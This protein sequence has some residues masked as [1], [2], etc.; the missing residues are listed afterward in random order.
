[1]VMGIF[2]VIHNPEGIVLG[3]I[4]VLILNP[5]TALCQ[6]QKQGMLGSLGTTSI[7]Q[8]LSG[9]PMHFTVKEAVCALCRFSVYFE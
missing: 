5:L 1:M 7:S 3:M 6:L 9:V 2:K 4:P 8:A